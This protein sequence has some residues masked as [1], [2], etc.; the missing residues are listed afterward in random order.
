MKYLNPNQANQ[1]LH[2]TLSEGR[3]YFTTAFTHYL[4]VLQLEDNGTASNNQLAQVLTVVSEN[5]RDTEVTLTTVGLTIEGQ[6]FYK[7]YG[8]NS[9]SNLDPTNAAVVG[10][11]ESGRAFIG[12]PQET[13]TPT[14]QRETV[15]YGKK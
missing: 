2:L 9:A 8:Q 13:I 11:V 6:Y 12:T 3:Q 5:T 1:T 7:V 4:M 10:L 14:S 15:K